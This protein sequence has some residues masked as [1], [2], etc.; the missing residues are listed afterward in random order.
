MDSYGPLILSKTPRLRTFR[1]CDSP[2]LILSNHKFKHSMDVQFQLAVLKSW[3]KE[4]PTLC[5]AALTE[6]FQWYK[7]D[8]LW[9][10]SIDAPEHFASKR[11]YT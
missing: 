8:G 9:T 11:R 2:T 3:E 6:T 4:C 1:V 7:I 10:A 5:R